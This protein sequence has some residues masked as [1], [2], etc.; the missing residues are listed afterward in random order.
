[1]T[2]QFHSPH[3]PIFP[4]EAIRKRVHKKTA[5]RIL[6]FILCAYFICYLDRVNISF[7]SLEMNASI[8]LSAASYGLGAAI[9]FV[10]YFIFEVP[11]NLALTKFGPRIWIARIMITWGILAGCMSLVQGPTSFYIMRFLLGVAEAGFFPAMILYLTYWF[12]QQRRGQMTAIFFMA[13]PL[14]G[15]IGAPLSTWL[16]TET[17]GLFGLEGWQVMFVAEAIPSVIGGIVALFW[18]VD[19]PSKAKFLTVEERTWLDQE[20]AKEADEVAAAGHSHKGILKTLV[21]P[22][23]IFL[24]LIYLGLEFGEYALGFFLPQM[25]EALNQSFGSGL[26]LVQVGLITAVPSLVGV[27]SMVYWGRRSDR[28]KERTWH[29]VVPTIIGATA[30]CLLPLATDLWTNMLLFSITSAAIFSAIPVFWQLPSRYLTGTAAAVGIALINSVGNISG[31]LGPS[32]TGSLKT[33]TGTYN[34]GYY[35][36]GIFLVLAAV[37]A[38]V[39]RSSTRKSANQPEQDLVVL[40]D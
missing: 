11:S 8:G 1:M 14:S 15:L 19:H 32:I 23:V 38:L 26:S 35:V 7:A 18:L 2:A 37:G 10:A 29:I 17:H 25:V 6:P 20:L 13:V 39:L 28:K 16:M 4:D 24:G 36:L 33:L 3:R 5:L 22:A 31:I 21:R 34:S 12:P 30:I 9:F 27:L 40:N